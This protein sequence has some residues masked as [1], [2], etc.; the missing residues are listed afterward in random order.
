L[1]T[2]VRV[3]GVVTAE[4]GRLGTP[5]LIAIQDESAAIVVR[6]PD[7]ERHPARG[8]RIEVVGRLF[9]PYGQLEV[10]IA[11]GGSTDRGAGTAPTSRQITAADLGESTEARLVG[12]EGRLTGNPRRAT[13]G[14]LTVDAVDA[15]G[16]AFRVTV[17]A[18]ARIDRS[19]LV[20][21]TRYAFTGV[22]GQRATRAGA[23]DGYRIW[24]RDRRDIVKRT[25][26][27]NGSGSSGTGAGPGVTGTTGAAGRTRD[28][29]SPP[30]AGAGGAGI[31]ATG[32]PPVGTPRVDLAA[33]RSF[34]GRVVEVAGLIIERR[35]TGVLLDDGTARAWLVIRGP[36]AE[37]GLDLVAGDA[38][39]ASGTVEGDPG[40]EQVVVDDPTAIVLAAAL[41]PRMASPSR[42]PTDPA[43]DEGAALPGRPDET[44][45][46][47]ARPSGAGPRD[48]AIAIGLLGLVILGAGALI[49]AARTWFERRRA[50]RRL[51]TRL[52]A[53]ADG[54]P[55]DRSGRLVALPTVAGVPSPAPSAGPAGGPAPAMVGRA[56]PTLGHE[57]PDAS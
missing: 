40:R 22:V 10:R 26:T 31:A 50:A 11:R 56:R 15:A 55:G 51:A 48:L 17:D 41:R 8:R 32:R 36:A 24:L 6:L 35:D 16:R 33:L 13:S 18:S 45:I 30:R 46:E 54:L 25:E 14:D 57:G 34:R 23:S 53:V 28:G 27:A 49:L 12:I 38:V 39:Q 43:I 5:P 4:A 47:G 21:G 3:A 7:G 42:R 52:A 37:T 19:I 1:G 9:A 29:T 2:T 20:K 44:A